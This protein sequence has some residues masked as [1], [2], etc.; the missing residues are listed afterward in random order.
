MCVYV[1]SEHGHYTT[2]KV[3]SWE[4]LKEYEEWTKESA[5]CYSWISFIVRFCVSRIDVNVE[6]TRKKEEDE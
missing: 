3:E 2:R 5:F 4:K 1:K 6:I